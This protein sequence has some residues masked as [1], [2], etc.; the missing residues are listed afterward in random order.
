MKLILVLLFSLIAL[1]P[2]AQTKTKIP[3]YFGFRVSP[4]FPTKFIGEPLL[5]VL[6]TEDNFDFSTTIM[7]KIGFSFGGT[8]RAGL[9]KLISLETG[10]NYTQRNFDLEMSVPDSNLFAPSDLSFVT[11]DVPINALFYIKMS[12]KWYT[13]ASLGVAINFKPTDIGKRTKP[14][15][16]HEFVNL[17]LIPIGKKVSFDLN[18]NLGFEFRSQKSGFFYLGGSARVPFS[19]LFEFLSEY[20]YQGFN[21]QAVGEVDGSYLSIDF[22]Y[23]FPN[24]RTKGAQFKPGPIEQ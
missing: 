4:V 21:R 20:S 18:A 2:M 1:L 10:I 13:N 16:P 8:V 14:G 7:Q 9:T 15:G 23:F 24:I 22:K 17:G 5:T 12:E 6:N 19:P 3:S 11:Y